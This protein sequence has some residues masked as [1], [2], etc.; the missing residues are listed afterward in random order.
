VPAQAAKTTSKLAIWGLVLGILGM[1]FFPLAFVGAVLG[2]M[3]LIRMSKDRQL[4]GQALAIIAIC[5]TVVAIVVNGFLAALAIPAYVGYVRRAKT[6]EASTNLKWIETRLV[7]HHAETGELRAIP[8]RP[9]GAP[10]PE[11]VPWTEADLEPWEPLGFEP[12][13]TYYA[14][15]VALLDGGARVVLRA[16]GDLDG[17][18]TWST[19]ER[20]LELRDGQLVPGDDGL[21]I[22][23][24]IE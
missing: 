13:P 2:V 5:L 20:T 6:A 12:E 8:R 22:E 18:D 19:F 4:G 3:A 15:E 14:Y 16:L 7:A 9:L 17:D 24:E 23:N 21:Y 10:G 1:C 11:K